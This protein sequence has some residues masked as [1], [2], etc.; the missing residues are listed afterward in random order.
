MIRKLLAILLT[1]VML[2]CAAPLSVTADID[3]PTTLGAPEHFGASHYYVD[4]LYFTFSTP[5]DLRSYIEK[6]AADDPDN[7]QSFSVN[8]QVDYKIN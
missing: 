3:P 1:L 4:Q 7:K 2:I 5:D 6:R 8:F